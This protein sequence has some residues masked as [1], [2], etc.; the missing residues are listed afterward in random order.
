MNDVSEHLI[1]MENI[2]IEINMWEHPNLIEKQVFFLKALRNKC[3]CVYTLGNVF[4]G[5]V[6]DPGKL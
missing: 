6:S 3:F 2:K 1:G 4:I 5:C